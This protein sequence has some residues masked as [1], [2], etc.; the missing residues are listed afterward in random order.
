MEAGLGQFGDLRLERGGRFLFERLVEVGQ[1]GVCVGTLGGRRAGEIRITRFSRDDRVTPAEMFGTA[2]ARTGTMVAGRYVLA[3]QDTTTLRDDGKKNSLLL[4][5]TIAVDALDGAL[6]GLVHAEVLCRK[7]GKKKSRK[8]RPFAEKESRRWLTGTEAA[9][10]LIGAGAACV[11]VIADC[12]GDIYEEFACKP[13][14]VELLIRAAQDRCLNDGRMLFG[15]T[16]ALPALGRIAIEL[17]A[18]PSR[19]ARAATLELRVCTVQIARPSRPSKEAAA[20]P[21]T[22]TINLVEAREVDPP[23]N[24]EVALWRL[25]NTQAVNSLTDAK[26]IVGF[27]RQRWTIEQVFRTIKTNGFD[28]EAVGIAEPMP[29]LNLAAATL[30]VGIQVMQMVRARDGNTSRPLEDVF[31]PADQPALEAACAKL[32]GKT[33]RQKNPHPKGSLAYAA[34]V[35]ARLGGWTGYYGKPGPIVILRGFL[36]FRAIAHGWALGRL[37]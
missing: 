21:A 32:E 25:L 18:T 20:L 15:C 34:W 28:I 36:R 14:S 27:Y 7:G 8:Q 6:Y 10:G 31:D 19:A 3:V 16:D 29:F 30:I 33:D 2:A 11:T 1:S 13:A 35:C 24:T 37:L 17:P 5:P 12:E 22:V 9:A 23:P 4:H 26:T